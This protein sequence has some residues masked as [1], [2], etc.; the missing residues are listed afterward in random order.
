M[1]CINTFANVVTYDV[2]VSF[3]FVLFRLLAQCEAII[4]DGTFNFAP[5]PFLQLY[6]ISVYIS[7]YYIQVAYFL[8]RDKTTE[9]YENMWK[10]LKRLAEE[11][12]GVILD[13]ET[14]ITDFEDAAFLAAKATCPRFFLRGCRFHL[15]QSW[16][17]H[18]QQET[19]LRVSYKDTK[20][21]IG[22]S[23]SFFIRFIFFRFLINVFY[24][25]CLGYWLTMLFGLPHLPPVIVR[26]AF[27]ILCMN[28]PAGTTV[29]QAY[30]EKNYVETTK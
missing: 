10:A 25:C 12:A 21:P 4:G 22:T 14:L 30:L 23:R 7:G 15:G 13:S 20:T 19:L 3:C 16:W 11:L 27:Q 17:R 24:F 28:A 5:K 9:T 2:F 1:K 18:I 26:R 29:F 6:T 8:L